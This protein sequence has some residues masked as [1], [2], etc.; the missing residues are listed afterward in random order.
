M[1]AVPNESKVATRPFYWSLRREVWENHSL[2]IGPLIVA[3]VVLFGS[4]VNAIHL[5]QRRQAALLLPELARRAAIEVQYDVAAGVL[6]MTAFFVGVFYCLDALYGER[7]ER[8]ILFWKS[9]PVSDLTSVLAKATIPLAIL[10]LIILPIIV[11]TQLLIMLISTAALLKSGLAGTTWTNFNLFKET[12]VLI[13]GLIV[14]E[15][16]HAPVYGWMLLVS[17]WAR[18][19]PF[20]WAV[21][22]PL[23]VIIFEKVTF[24]TSHVRDLL[25]YRILGAGNEAFIFQKHG[26][27]AN[28]PLVQLTPGRFLASPGLWL[29]LVFAALCIAVAIRL[30]RY[31]GP[32]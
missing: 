22:P 7:R 18:R 4:M 6:M 26:E 8:S 14:L 5:P 2:Y 25:R 13:Y 15:L 17:S 10:P 1:N 9:L 19:A 24:D 11:G 29:G 3:I 30:R 27:L 21:L 28:G 31:R 32:I 16:W 23:A 12:F 20:L